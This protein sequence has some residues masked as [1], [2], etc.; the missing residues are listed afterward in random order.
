MSSIVSTH[1]G[2]HTNTH[3]HTHTHTLLGRVAHLCFDVYM[4]TEIQTEVI[5]CMSVFWCFVKMKPLM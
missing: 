3:A 2:H 4:Q 1:S 5:I